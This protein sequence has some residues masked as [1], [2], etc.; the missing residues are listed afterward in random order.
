MATVSTLSESPD[1]E[2]IQGAALLSN[3]ILNSLPNSELSADTFT[4]DDESQRE[5][6]QTR[7]NLRK[8][9]FQPTLALCGLRYLAT[10][11]HL[12]S[13][14]PHSLEPRLR[15][16]IDIH[17]TCVIQY[18]LIHDGATA[19]SGD[20]DVLS[21]LNLI[22]SFCK[23]FI[24]IEY[25]TCRAL[26]V[27][28]Q[29]ALVVPDSTSLS[30]RDHIYQGITY[31]CRRSPNVAL[32]LVERITKIYV[33][34]LQRLAMKGQDSDYHRVLFLSHLIESLVDAAPKEGCAKVY[35]R[36]TEQL[37]GSLT[38]LSSHPFELVI[39]NACHSVIEVLE[40]KAST[41]NSFA[42][43]QPAAMEGSTSPTSELHN[44]SLSSGSFPIP[45]DAQTRSS[46]NVG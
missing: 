27:A 38:Q 32:P 25:M 23:E 34:L 40:Y 7:E 30:Q 24:E 18:A 9:F 15:R 29:T 42:S 14:N 37:S 35:K 3:A 43:G 6:S 19:Y 33:R 12:G 2:S 17:L 1:D 45:E 20:K 8:G 13:S 46:F 39:Y 16:A 31:I 28:C 22:A 21:C 4:T 5:M 10:Q 26:F 44:L 11:L 41:S 36:L